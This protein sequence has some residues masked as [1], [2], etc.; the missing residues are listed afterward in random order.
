MNDDMNSNC[1]H[2]LRVLSRTDAE[3][4]VIFESFFLFEYIKERHGLS[5]SFRLPSRE[6]VH[7]VRAT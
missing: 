1:L 5:V 7:A 4:D 2:P 6:S 3:V